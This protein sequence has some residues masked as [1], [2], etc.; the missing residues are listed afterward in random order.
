MPPDIPPAAWAMPLKKL[1]PHV[2]FTAL[3]KSDWPAII[4]ESLSPGPYG[5]LF[6]KLKYDVRIWRVH[7]VQRVEESVE[8]FRKKKRRLDCP[9]VVV[10]GINMA[11]WDVARLVLEGLLQSVDK[12]ELPAAAPTWEPEE[13]T[14][15]DGGVI[16]VTQYLPLSSFVQMAFFKGVN[17]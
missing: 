12:S 11:V 2:L 6:S 9:M 13:P 5:T 7:V 1:C 10:L 14:N 8:G 17:T 15:E 16:S 3:Y 4:G